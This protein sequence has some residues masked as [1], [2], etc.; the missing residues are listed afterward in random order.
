[1]SLACCVTLPCKL[2]SGL[3]LASFW[4]PT[5]RYAA[6][7]WTYAKLDEAGESDVIKDAEDSFQRDRGD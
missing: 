6:T 1:M 4:F 7:R 2:R 3:M 5:G